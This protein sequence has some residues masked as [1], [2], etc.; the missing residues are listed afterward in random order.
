[1]LKIAWKNL[2]FKPIKDEVDMVIS[3]DGAR[4]QHLQAGLPRH[5]WE[6][7]HHVDGGEDEC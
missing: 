6:G 3:G 2:Q 7:V 4:L 5:G 1:M